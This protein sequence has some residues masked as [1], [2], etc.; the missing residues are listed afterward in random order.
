MRYNRYVNILRSILTET[1]HWNDD[2]DAVQYFNFIVKEPYSFSECFI[3]EGKL[4][5]E[6]D[7]YCDAITLP[8]KSQGYN[9]EGKFDI[10]AYVHEDW[11]EWINFFIAIYDDGKQFVIGDFENTIVAS[12]KET[13]E[14]FLKHVNVES[15]DYGDI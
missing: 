15:W 2:F 4:H 9:T 10:I 7:E 5:V 8:K 1:P 3:T 6:C 12:S 14:H 11:F 13:L